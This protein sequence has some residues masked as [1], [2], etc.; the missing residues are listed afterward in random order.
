MRLWSKCW[1]IKQAPKR[2]LLNAKCRCWRNLDLLCTARA[3]PCL[4]EGLGEPRQTLVL[5]PAPRGDG[6]R[7][8]LLTR[9]ETDQRSSDSVLCHKPQPAFSAY[10]G[11]VLLWQKP[12]SAALPCTLGTPLVQPGS[13]T[14]PSSSTFAASPQ[15]RTY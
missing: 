2:L 9:L 1:F 12:G 10:K 4:R 6:K 3:G 5:P 8:A 13:P 15:R 7:K 11:Q 14:A